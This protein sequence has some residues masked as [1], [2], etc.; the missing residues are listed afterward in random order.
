MICQWNEFA[1]QPNDS[2]IYTDCYSVQYS[3]DIEPTQLDGWGYRGNGGRGYYYLVLTKALI[4]L[5]RG[6]IPG[7]TVMAISNPINGGWVASDRLNVTWTYIGKAPSSYTILLDGKV[8]AKD[9]QGI[10]YRVYDSNPN[11]YMNTTL[12]SYSLN[13]S[14]LPI[15]QY[16]T[17]TVI[18]NGAKSYFNLTAAYSELVNQSR[19]GIPCESTV[20][21]FYNPIS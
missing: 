1:G 8:V 16:Y 11:E 20:S 15:R 6:D 21:F 2:S 12:L 9:V 18:A 13:L 5:Y 19:T 10:P 17:V 7:A 14:G 4:E 3:N